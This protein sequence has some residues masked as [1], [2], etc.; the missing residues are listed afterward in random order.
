VHRASIH[1]HPCSRR[2]GGPA[3]AVL[4]DSRTAEQ[5]GRPRVLAGLHPGREGE[6]HG[7]G[8]ERG[9]GRLPED[10]VRAARA[11]ACARRVVVVLLLLLKRAHFAGG[12]APTAGR[13]ASFAG[14]GGAEFEFK[15]RASA[16]WRSSLGVA[17]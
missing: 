4:R 7:R 2:A 3:I 8:R 10:R 5:C 17:T 13:G 6:N 9:G 16:L 12:V 1:I 15:R 14:S 11:L